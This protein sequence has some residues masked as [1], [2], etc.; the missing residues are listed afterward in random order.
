MY[1]CCILLLVYSFYFFKG[2]EKLKIYRIVDANINRVSEGL[3]VIEDIE[4]FIYEDEKTSKSLREIRHK[5]RKS[6]TTE[7]LI[8]NRNSTQDIGLDISKTSTLDKKENIQ[9]LLLSNFK[10][11]EEG[12]RSIE[13]TLKVLG[14]YEISK[15]YEDL[16]YQVYNI[17]K[18]VIGK[19]KISPTDIYA[20]LGEE[21]SHGRNNIEIVKELIDANVKLIQYREKNKNKQEKFEQCKTIRQ[22]TKKF[23][24]TFIV[25]DDV[26]I[27]LAVNADGIHIGQE[28]MPIEQVKNIAPN[29]IVGLSTHNKE[30]AKEAVTKG[31][32]YIGV[33]P[34]FDTKTKKDLEKSQGL[35]YL[36]WVSE[37]I[38]MPYVAIGG[39]K[40]EN[41]LL[42]KNNGANCF[43]MISEIVGAKA[44]KDKVESIRKK[45][46]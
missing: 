36:K 38:S 1:F 40:E 12:L 8:I 15:I 4:R 31:A 5:V 46:N 41:I 10:R 19:E 7:E 11:V 32:D 29:M 16:R 17:E 39:I 35:E 24:I 37:N 26:D 13:E 2:G 9:T 25:N 27:A 22:M 23:D 30:Q 18:I 3:R 44:I 21:F 43:A 33:G 14:Y 20:I 34:I 28:D 45:I 6:F 42:A